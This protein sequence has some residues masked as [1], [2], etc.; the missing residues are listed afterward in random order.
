MV[1]RPKRQCPALKIKVKVTKLSDHDCTPVEWCVLFPHIN[2]PTASVKD[3]HIFFT[4]CG[5][6]TKGPQCDL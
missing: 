5:L 1:P 6:L 2:L 3:Y 4:F